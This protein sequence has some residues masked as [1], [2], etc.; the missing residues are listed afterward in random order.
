MYIKKRIGCVQFAMIRWARV[1]PEAG[2]GNQMAK[3]K[4]LLIF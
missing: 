3:T 1:M 4:V 2:K